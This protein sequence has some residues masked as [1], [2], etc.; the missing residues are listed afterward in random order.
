MKKL[1]YSAAAALMLVACGEK[2]TD[3]VFYQGVTSSSGPNCHTFDYR[4][5]P[6]T[7]ALKGVEDG[8]SSTVTLA[9]K[10]EHKKGEEV[11]EFRENW[12]VK[13]RGRDDAEGVEIHLDTD[14]KSMEPLKSS[15]EGNITEVVFTGKAATADLVKLNGQK[16]WTS[17]LMP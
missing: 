1:F 7:L 12:Y 9:L 15:T 4:V 3:Y 6:D 2:S 13:V 11:K 10:F 14:D 16:A 8:D 17:V 5:N